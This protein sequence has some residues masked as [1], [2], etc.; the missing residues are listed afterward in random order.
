MW[1]ES[2]EF[3]KKIDP[4]VRDHTAF[5]LALTNRLI[6]LNSDRKWKFD[7][8]RKRKTMIVLFNIMNE[9]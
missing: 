4:F 7:L 1:Y 3:Q 5:A 6:N 9:Y 2:Q 8:K